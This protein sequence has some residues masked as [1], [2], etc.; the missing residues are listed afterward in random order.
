MVIVINLIIFIIVLFIYLHLIFQYKQN[1]DLEI[2]EIEEP[3]KGQLEE[4]CDLKQPVLFK[5]ESN[6]DNLNFASLLEN[7]SAFDIKV[8][9]MNDLEDDS[10]E[11]YIPLT[12][13]DA[14]VLLEKDKEHKYISENN[15]EFLDETSLIKNIN[16][17]D[18][19][20]RPYFLSFIEYDLLLGF[21]DSYT[22]FK[23]DIFFRNYFLVTEG[24]IIIRLTPPKNSK[25]LDIDKNYNTLEYKS[26]MNIWNV[27]EK[28]KNNFEKI[29]CL[30]IELTKDQIIYIPPYWFYSIK[31]ID[32]SVIVNFKYSTFMNNLA[33]V[34]DYLMY[35]FQNNNTKIQI[36]NIKEIIP[37]I[38]KDI[39]SNII[40]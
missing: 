32:K 35:L 26:K 5:F 8:R 24:K 36:S 30:D 40:K 2:L 10:S 17:S 16:T 9:N 28:Y 4:I 19:F 3:T 22:I 27:Q 21:P 23:Y 11:E 20:L 31:Y 39:S 7:Y 14:V 6:L 1:N 37:K 25:Y 33:N 18:L 15:K 13:R 34:P 38:K 29:K 12:I